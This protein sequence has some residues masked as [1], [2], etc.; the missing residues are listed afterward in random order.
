MVGYRL[1]GQ[2]GSHLSASFEPNLVAHSS[3]VSTDMG[4]NLFVFLTQDA[5]MVKVIKRDLARDPAV[6]FV[7]HSN[8]LNGLRCCLD[9]RNREEAR[10]ARERPWIPVS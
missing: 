7:V 2:P 5:A 6:M 8:L 1:W 4:F 10:A 3:V 9:S